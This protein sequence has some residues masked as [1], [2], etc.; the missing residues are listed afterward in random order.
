MGKTKDSTKI[1]VAILGTFGPL[2]ALGK[3]IH[4]IKQENEEK[5]EKE[6]KKTREAE[7]KKRNGGFTDEEKHGLDLKERELDLINR[8]K[9]EGFEAIQNI[10][11][12]CEEAREPGSSRHLKDV[13]ERICRILH[14][15]EYRRPEERPMLEEDEITQERVSAT[16]LVGNLIKL[17]DRVIIA[18][19]PCVGKSSFAVQL[20]DDISSGNVSKLLP[21]GSGPIIPQPTYLF[22]KEQDSDDRKERMGMK[23]FSSR[24]RRM[25]NA[26]FP[27][28]YCLLDDLYDRVAMLHENATFIYDNLKS[29]CGEL[30]PEQTGHLFEGLAEIQNQAIA[31][32][33]RITIIFVTHFVK[34]V[35]GIPEMSDIAGAANITRF[36][37]NV[38]CLSSTKEDNIALMNNPKLRHNAKNKPIVF[39]LVKDSEENP[40]VHFQYVRTVSGNEAEAI[41]KGSVH[42]TEAVSKEDERNKEKYDE[43]VKRRIVELHA[44][45]NSYRDIAEILK[46][47]GVQISHATVS[48]LLKEMTALQGALKP[49]FA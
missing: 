10:R 24:L 34:D 35:S 16:P 20:A 22:D 7:E 39:K 36:A 33:I 4:T 30:S 14:L 29:I 11:H 49:A 43:N 32:G 13:Q 3:L 37:K 45:G 28:A 26:N 1:V 17:G 48:K 27:T 38:I 2:V 12:K 42:C 18:G 19:N 8:K 6:E 44:N 21:V 25:E 9:A 41:M 31:R 47:E 5:K 15:G 40:M 46:G 23:H